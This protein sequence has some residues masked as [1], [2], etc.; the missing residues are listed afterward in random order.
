VALVF[1][2]VGAFVQGEEL[3]HELVRHQRLGLVVV[4]VLDLDL[5][6]RVD[7]RGD[8]VGA[9]VSCALTAAA[10]VVADSYSGMPWLAVRQR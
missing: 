7:D 8:E 4:E 10:W 6:Q 2:E 5:G 3:R 1:V 9:L